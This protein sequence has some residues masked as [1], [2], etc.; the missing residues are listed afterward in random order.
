MILLSGIV[1]FLIV[2]A[3][4]PPGDS[5]LRDKFVLFILNDCHPSFLRHDLDRANPLAIWHGIDNP[6][7]QKLKDLFLN[8]FLHGFVKP[9]LWFPR[10]RRI[11]INRDTMSAESGTNPFEVLE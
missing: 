6:G 9:L 1:K 7:V 4:P 11:G 2:N 5:S 3:H 10:W 8:N